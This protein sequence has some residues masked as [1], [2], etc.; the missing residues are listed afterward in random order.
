MHEDAID[1]LIRRWGEIYPDLDA[2]AL[3]LVG[4]VLV[5]AELLDRGVHQALAREKLTLGQFDILATLRREDATGGLSPGQLLKSVMLSSGGMT[6]R[7]DRLENAGLI[8]RTADPQD[9][10]GV[11]VHLTPRGRATIDRATAVRFAQARESLPALSSVE[12]DML[13]G[14]L[15]RWLCALTQEGV[16]ASS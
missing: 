2:S 6:S 10:R 9:R 5:L 3:H 13:A 12:Q 7:L 1:R 16:N 8:V 11:V 15:R 14:L 4:R